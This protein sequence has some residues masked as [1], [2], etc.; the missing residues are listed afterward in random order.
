MQIADLF[1]ASY[2]QIPGNVTLSRFKW[3]AYFLRA[4]LLATAGLEDRSSWHKWSVYLDRIF[5]IQKKE[6]VVEIY[7]KIKEFRT[8]L[9]HYRVSQNLK[10]FKRFNR[11]NEK[12]TLE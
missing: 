3:I 2:W 9:Q 6:K 11:Q 12:A 7:G 10:K 8:G 4:K 1:E 5:Q